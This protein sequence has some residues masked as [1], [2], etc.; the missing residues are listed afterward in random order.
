MYSMKHTALI[1][2]L[3]AG[4]ALAIAI[5]LFA[6]PTGALDDYLV[7][8]L[9]GW[10]RRRT[11]ITSRL[12]EVPIVLYHN[13]DG[14]G[15]FSLG[16]DTL[17]A[18]FEYYRTAGIRVIPLAELVDRLE[19]PRP[20]RE[21]VI[22]ITFDDGFFAM[23]TK[24]LPLV[25][26]FGYPVTLFVY[27][28]TIYSRAD[29]NLTWSRLREMQQAGIDVQSHTISHRDL[30]RLSASDNPDARKRLFDELVM[31]RRLIELYLKKPV[32]LLAFPYGHY[33]DRVIDVSRRAG[34]TRVFSTDYGP[35][36]ITRNNFCL[37]RRHIKSDYSLAVIQS[38]VQ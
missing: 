20:Y 28:D 21:R 12:L 17:R 34:Y 35:N 4:A 33:D 3:P 13:I 27:A 37:R 16:L 22:A 29:T 23:Y 38:L 14:K 6:L 24:L 2:A 36:I 32:R 31:S 7:T 19:R 15:P 10:E 11:E 8:T 25:R 26:E 30:V 5:G 9:P 1:L 18:H